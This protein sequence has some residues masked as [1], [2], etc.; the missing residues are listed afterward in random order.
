MDYQL[1]VTRIGEVQAKPELTEASRD[2]LISIMRIIRSA[3]V[4]LN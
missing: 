3:E 1:S 4:I 2:F